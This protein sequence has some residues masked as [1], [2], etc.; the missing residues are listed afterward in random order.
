MKILR[1]TASH[2]SVIFASL[3]VMTLVSPYLNSAGHGIRN[4]WAVYS[5]WLL[6]T[7]FWNHGSLNNTY[8]ELK[9]RKY[10]VFSLVSW[11]IVVIL[12]AVLTHG[13]T[14]DLHFFTML[15]MSMVIFMQISY[16]A[17]RDGSASVLLVTVIL[18]GVEVL[19][20]IPTLWS[21]PAL[22]RI[23]MGVAATPE[24]IAE[25]G[26]AS[27]GQYGYYT[28]LA[29]VLPI[30]VTRAV[31]SNGTKAIALWIIAGAIAFAV[32]IATFMGAILLMFLGLVILGIFHITYAKSSIKTLLLYVGAVAVL[33]VTSM[34][35]LGEIEQVSYVADKATNQ[36]SGIKDRGIK[37]GDVTE[38]SDLFGLSF[39]TFLENPL[40][41]VGPVTN[42]ENPILFTKIGGHSSWL[43]QLAEYGMLGFCFYILFIGLVIR[44][45]TKSF[46][47][48]KKIS[49]IKICCL[50]QLT[51][52]FLFIL[53]GIYD[54]VIVVTEIFVL[55][56]FMSSISATSF[57]GMKSASETAMVK[58]P[59]L[60][61]IIRP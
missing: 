39:N 61:H 28:G 7:F 44:R 56:Y 22:A 9:R 34:S 50:G 15:T 40:L 45:I 25:A 52:C 11:L 32:S 46:L 20:S 3:F 31:V 21:Q 17:Q 57:K 41:G 37:E 13:F 30:I 19:R 26:V 2:I 24:M 42:R 55:F 12:N 53:G 49:D 18:I 5:L 4:S 29:I 36:F 10:E 16:S 33:V 43:D 35:V 23:I 60:I 59:T 54:P 58:N 14:G 38:R 8:I 47:L 48:E 27:V 1:F 6:T 51:S